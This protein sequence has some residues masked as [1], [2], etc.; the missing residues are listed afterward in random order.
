M[1]LRSVSITK[2]AIVKMSLLQS[3][4]FLPL[5]NTFEWACMLLW[6]QSLVIPVLT[7]N[8]L[9][10]WRMGT[11]WLMNTWPS[12][13][14]LLTTLAFVLVLLMRVRLLV[15]LVMAVVLLML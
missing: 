1:D 6:W 2:V 15:V 7:R 13:T 5:Q 4:D 11:T 14:V 8:D 9:C 12:A 3:R 10:H